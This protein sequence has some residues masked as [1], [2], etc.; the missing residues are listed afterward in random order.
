[1]FI[2]LLVSQLSFK[3]GVLLLPRLSDTK[4]DPKKIEAR[5]IKVF[6]D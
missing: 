6:S 3:G 4:T 1:M 2:H 5:L